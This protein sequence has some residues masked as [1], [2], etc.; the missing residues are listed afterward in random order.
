MERIRLNSQKA[1][2]INFPEL[3]RLCT[4]LY[5]W[6]GFRPGPVITPGHYRTR[7][8]RTIL[9]TGAEIRDYCRTCD[10]SRLRTNKR[11]ELR[12]LRSAR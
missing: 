1:E 4:S 8:S 9:R 6:P 2:F 5:T 11:Q 7:K 10:S 3:R 12:N